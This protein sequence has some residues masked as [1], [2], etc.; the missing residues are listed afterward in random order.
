VLYSLLQPRLG[1]LH[2]AA[3]PGRARSCRTT[4]PCGG[5]PTHPL[6]EL[7]R[8]RGLAGFVEANPALECQDAQTHRL[9]GT[10]ERWQLARVDGRRALEAAQR[11][12]LETT[13]LFGVSEEFDAFLLMAGR[14][15]GWPDLLAVRQN[16][17]PPDEALAIRDEELELVRRRNALDVELHAFAT[18]VFRE[19]A[20]ALASTPRGSRR[21]GARRAAFA[22]LLARGS[23]LPAGAPGTAPA[24]PRASGARR[25]A[26]PAEALPYD[27]GLVESWRGLPRA[28]RVARNVASLQQ[29]VVTWDQLVADPVPPDD[30]VRDP[31]LFTHVKKTGGTTL[32]RVVARNYNAGPPRRDQRSDAVCASPRAVQARGRDRRDAMG[33]LLRAHGPPQVRRRRLQP[34][35]AAHHPRHA[36]ARTRS[37]GC[38][39]T[40]GACGPGRTIPCT[41]SPGGRASPSSW[42]RIPQVECRDAQAHGLAGTLAPRGVAADPDGAAVLEAARQNLMQTVSLF[43]IA[44]EFDAFLLV[45]Q[46]L[47][48]WP[49][50]VYSR[51]NVTPRDEAPPL[52]EEDVELVRRLNPLD[53]ELHALATRVFHE[54][55]EAL[56]I[57]P[58]DV[59]AQQRVQASFVAFLPPR[60]APHTG[61]PAGLARAASETPVRR[62]ATCDRRAGRTSPTARALP[63]RRSSSPGA[64]AAAARCCGRSSTATSGTSLLRALPRQPA[65]GDRLRPDLSQPPGRE[66]LLD[67]IRPLLETVRALHRPEFGFDR[68]LLEAGDQHAPLRDYLAALIAAADG[69]RPVLQFNRCDFRCPGCAPSSPTRAGPRRAR[70]ARVVGLDRR[71]TSRRSRPT[72]P[73]TSTCSSSC[74]GQSRSARPSP[75]CSTRAAPTSATTCCG[76]SARSWAR[77]RRTSR[78]TSTPSCRPTPSAGSR[79]WRASRGSR[80]TSGPRPARSSSEVPTGTWLRHHPVEYFAEIEERCERT[81]AALGLTERFGLEP[82]AAIRA[83]HAPEWVALDALARE[84]ARPALAAGSALRGEVTRLLHALR[85]SS[86]ADMPADSAG[87][88]ERVG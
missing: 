72:I 84:R 10:Q 28:E 45:C 13:S 50:I 32:Q 66:G 70:R 76:G 41:R 62:A 74:S 11:H 40:T 46:R 53:L 31:L 85:A 86:E 43:G 22:G 69:R 37:R 8:R 55:V 29:C 87:T 65:P 47:L 42:R 79:R 7:A 71:G 80:A 49:D 75:S 44:E 54:R 33:P 48:G 52:R 14:L 20:Q 2:A 38:S 6:H 58:Q 15:L 5:K 9:A 51:R 63:V 1:A 18:R 81:L 77:G 25:A 34:A 27:T 73:T 24:P 23:V 82:L 60:P 59:A 35:P 17:T 67:R 21:T 16:V 78:S 30:L 83:A 61:A 68:L 26:R 12:L 56:G 88:G 3:R 64:S 39:P 19:R 4:G 36:A 57:T